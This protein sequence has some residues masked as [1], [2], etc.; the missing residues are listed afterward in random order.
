MPARPPLYNHR[1]E[2]KYTSPW[3]CPPPRTPPYVPP[4]PLPEHVCS[5]RCDRF[6][7]WYK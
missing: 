6:P 4:P 2:A 1:T 5:P 3:R 7:P